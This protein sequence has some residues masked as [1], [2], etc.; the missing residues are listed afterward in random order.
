MKTL[1]QFLKEALDVYRLNE[2]VATYLV[3]PEEIIIQAPETYQENDIQ[4]YM[5]DKWLVKL[6]SFEDY[7]EKFFGTN[8]E[9][10]IDVYFEYD[11]FEHI[12]IEPRD[13]IE[14]DPKLDS[15]KTD[16]DTK[17]DY[18][19]I[20]NLKYVISFDRFDLVGVDDD[21]VKDK[22][23]DIFK[24]AESNKVNKWPIEIMF[25]EENLEYRK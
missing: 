11:T 6:P 10:I 4:A 15:K 8:N 12:D 3:Q 1:V 19:K 23:I 20:T 16:K 9:S 14:W 7:S 22:L 5:D 18:F 2:V 17:L 13:Y 25:D 24:A 21:T